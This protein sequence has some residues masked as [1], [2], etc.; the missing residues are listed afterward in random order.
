MLF[1]GDDGIFGCPPLTGV[2]TTC[3]EMGV[4]LAFE[5]TTHHA[6]AH[7]CGCTVTEDPEL[8][9][10]DVAPER[11]KKS[12]GLRESQDEGVRKT[13]VTKDPL[14]VLASATAL[15]RPD[16]TSVKDHLSLQAAKVMSYS[17][18]FPGLPLVTTFCSAF[19]QRHRTAA[20]QAKAAVRELWEKE[21]GTRDKISAA[22][23]AFK[24]MYK[25][26]KA[27]NLLADFMKFEVPDCV[28]RSS[29]R[30]RQACEHLYGVPAALYR[31]AEDQI[32][33]QLMA[34]QDKLAIPAISAM[35]TLA[36]GTR[37]MMT[38]TFHDARTIADE[39]EVQDTL[40]SSWETIKDC[41]A[42]LK[43][44][45]NWTIAVFTY[46]F[47][48]YALLTAACFFLVPSLLY[49]VLRPG[50]G[51][52]AARFASCFVAGLLFVP[53]ILLS[54]WPFLRALAMLRHPKKVMMVYASLPITSYRW[55]MTGFSWP[56]W[57]RAYAATS[58]AKAH[59]EAM[60]AHVSEPDGPAPN[61]S[62]F[63]QTGKIAN[64]L[65][66]V[67]QLR[68]AAEG[69]PVPAQ[70]Q[71]EVTRAANTR[72]TA[73]SVYAREHRAAGFTVSSQEMM[74]LFGTPYYADGGPQTRPV[75]PAPNPTQSPPPSAPQ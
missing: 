22:S 50:L 40:L 18:A 61:A 2:E 35:R 38:R 56:R 70:A 72:D 41:G 68:M 7:F 75:P 51:H 39:Y 8:M 33:E 37:R 48:W 29:A 65:L 24:E 5:V 62:D 25:D 9:K 59:G 14:Q 19:L 53:F 17:I 10:P 54:V 34:G 32:E 71:L 60:L 26:L 66:V 63:P 52:K 55:L 44:V 46:F 57:S 74:E 31:A 23:N 58:R 47:P 16:I 36:E 28:T 11:I 15:L 13:V 42:V 69:L 43:I 67:N 1:E 3:R 45:F 49:L 20:M 6:L 4:R 73:A 27:R 21:G 30:V 64:K 12:G